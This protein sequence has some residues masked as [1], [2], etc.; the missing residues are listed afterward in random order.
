MSTHS[1]SDRSN[2]GDRIAQGAQS[3]S[4]AIKAGADA[5]IQGVY[6]QGTITL[7][8]QVL[9]GVV[10][11]LAAGPVLEV[12]RQL[13][14]QVIQSQINDASAAVGPARQVLS[15]LADIHRVCG[16]IG[17]W[18]NTPPLTGI[19]RLIHRPTFWDDE[20][21]VCGEHLGRIR[22]LLREVTK[23]C[24]DAYSLSLQETHPLRFIFSSANTTTEVLAGT[25]ATLPVAR[26]TYGRVKDQ[27]LDVRRRIGALAAYLDGFARRATANIEDASLNRGLAYSANIVRTEGALLVERAVVARA[28]CEAIEQLASQMAGTKHPPTQVTPEGGNVRSL[29]PRA[30]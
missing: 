1:G 20:L 9:N 5:Y 23:Q 18:G 13:G 29:R 24:E 22:Y 17:V 26:I 16:P 14:E 21:G 28:A 12:A 19:R 7:L 6:A 4:S 30:S 27:A 11:P 3:L 10:A 2:T 15:A 8:K 25:P